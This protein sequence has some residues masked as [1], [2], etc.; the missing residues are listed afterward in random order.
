MSEPAIR[1]RGLY[2]SYRMG[3]VNL[4][5]LRGVSLTVQA[6]EF[7]G[8]VGAS[9]SGKSTLLHLIGLLDR[10]DAGH[11]ELAGQNVAHLRG[12]GG[13]HRS[14]RFA[15]DRAQRRPLRNA[16]GGSFLPAGQRIHRPQF[17]VVGRIVTARRFG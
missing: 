5:V 1:V 6:G 16:Q 4:H 8:I 11:V 15:R 2:K 9:G 3:R 7:V 12:L 10:P 13:P 17:L 14:G